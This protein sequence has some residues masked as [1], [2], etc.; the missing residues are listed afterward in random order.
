MTDTILL[1]GAS[2]GLGLAIAR[3]LCA[4]RNRLI[5]TAR[6]SSLPQF[7]KAG[8]VE[9]E[10]IRLRPLDVTRSDQRRRVV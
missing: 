3:E 5:L 1:T 7:A 9:S 4:S 8:I 10:R 6:E 2:S